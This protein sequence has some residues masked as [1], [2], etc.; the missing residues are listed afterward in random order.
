MD[1]WKLNK[2]R[3]RNLVFVRHRPEEKDKRDGTRGIDPPGKDG[4]V[5]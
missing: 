1:T 5:T 2:K 3:Y 4:D